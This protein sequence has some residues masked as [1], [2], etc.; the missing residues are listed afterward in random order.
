M[1]YNHPEPDSRSLETQA[2]RFAGAFLLP[3]H[4]LEAEWPRG[5]L[6]W[7]ELIALKQRWQ[8]SLG[9]IIYRADSW[10]CCRTPATCR[11]SS[12]CRASAGADTNRATSADRSGRCCRATPSERCDHASNLSLEDLAREARLPCWWSE[13]Y[14]ETPGSEPRVK[15]RL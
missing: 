2:H 10:D 1:H 11:P 5:R 7:P 8:V 15:V 4:A 6:R 14:L 12:T 3:P 9:A 13:Q